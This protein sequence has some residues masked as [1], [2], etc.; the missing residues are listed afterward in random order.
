M[1][2][3]IKRENATKEA[4]GQE[5]GSNRVKSPKRFADVNE[6]IEFHNEV[7]KVEFEAIIGSEITILEA[8][9]IRDF[10]SKFGRHDFMIVYA[11]AT[12]SDGSIAKFT[13]GTSGMVL[14]KRIMRAQELRWLPL[15]GTIMKPLDKSYYDIN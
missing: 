9:V 1:E 12:A 3:K 2:S 7:D 11:S 15:T 10:D 4:I 14:I 5:G 13:F 6:K 8:K